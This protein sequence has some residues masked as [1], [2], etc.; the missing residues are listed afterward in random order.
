MSGYVVV[1]PARNEAA[2][3]G[4][5]IASMLHQTVP[6][7]RWVIVDD[8]STDDTKNIATGLTADVDWIELVSRRDRGHRSAGTGVMEAFR[9]GLARIED[10]D[11]R[12]LVKLDADLEFDEDY[13]ERCLEAFASDATLGIA[14]GKVHDV[15]PDRI[16]HDPHPD[17]HVR[18]AT[19][20]YRRE[21]WKDI[22]GVIDAPGWDTLDEVKANQLGWKTRTLAEPPIYQLRPTGEAAGSWSNWVKNGA[23]AYRSGYHPAYVAA[24][25][26][27][28]LMRPPSITAPTGL[29]WGYL[30]AVLTK[31]DRVDD[32]ELLRY[33]KQ[34]QWNRLIGRDSMWR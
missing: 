19:K 30:K 13:F 10:T 17:F 22:G 4:R 26:G 34:Q 11:W 12:Y 7:Q 23:A 14:G 3:I 18:G 32:P 2:Y 29:I 33:V 20:I 28:R 16:V 9:A 8:G 27:R 21:C 24:R 15:Y 1:T 5:T 31:P 25:A 6:P